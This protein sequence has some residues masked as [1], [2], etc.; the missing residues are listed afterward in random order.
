MTRPDILREELIKSLKDHVIEVCFRKVTNGEE[1]NLKCTWMPAHLPKTPQGNPLE[2]LISEHEKPE[3]Q[4]VI[5][6][7]DVEKSGWRSFH[8]SEV[9]YMQQVGD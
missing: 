1:R 9:R 2:W 8:V 5:V 6:A 3:H 7:W 4:D